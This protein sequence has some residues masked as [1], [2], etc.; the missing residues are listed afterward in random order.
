MKPLTS[1]AQLLLRFKV[2]EHRRRTGRP[3]DRKTYQAIRYRAHRDTELK[4]ASERKQQR[5]SERWALWLIEEVN[6]QCAS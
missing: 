2:R 4:L 6:R 1:F 5:E 3:P